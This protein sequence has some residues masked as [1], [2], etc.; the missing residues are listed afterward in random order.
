MRKSLAAT[1]KII[2]QDVCAICGTH[3][4]I[5]IPMLIFM[6][7]AS[8]IN[9][10]PGPLTTAA[11]EMGPIIVGVTF[12]LMRQVHLVTKTLMIIKSPIALG[13]GKLN[14]T[15]PRKCLPSEAFTMKLV[16]VTGLKILAGCLILITANGLGYHAMAKV[17]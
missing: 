17:T 10:A 4:A 6:M 11:M 12:L 2:L 13:Q 16:E 14:P 5:P 7:M 3:G 15:S 1:V 9:H 8:I